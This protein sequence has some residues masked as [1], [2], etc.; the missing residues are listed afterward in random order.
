MV[1]LLATPCR[2]HQRRR[3]NDISLVAPLDGLK[4]RHFP[5]KDGQSHFPVCR[6]GPIQLDARTS[7]QLFDLMLH[8]RKLA[9][10]S[11]AGA[12]ELPLDILLEL[13]ELALRQA[14]SRLSRRAKR[15]VEG[16]ASFGELPS[17]APEQLL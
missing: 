14:E 4:G 10:A 5:S 9:L 12:R 7:E 8:E 16:D 17:D 1:S 11:A 2:L 13:A 15:R 6:H 3:L